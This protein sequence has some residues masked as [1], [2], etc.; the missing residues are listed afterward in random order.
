MRWIRGVN[1]PEGMTDRRVISSLSPSE[2]EKILDAAGGIL[3]DMS[4]ISNRIR[5][6]VTIL[7]E[8][9]AAPGN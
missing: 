4:V 8:T 6:L 1:T 7:T 2:K 3:E 9:P 5:Q